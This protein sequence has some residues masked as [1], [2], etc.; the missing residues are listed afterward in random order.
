MS[1]SRVC[2]LSTFVLITAIGTLAQNP[3]P[4]GL[5]VNSSQIPIPLGAVNPLT[6]N[7]HLE[8]PIASIPQRNGHTMS[9][10]LVFDTRWQT[11]DQFQA[12]W[13]GGPGWRLVFGPSQQGVVTSTTTTS[14]CPDGGYPNGSAYTTSNYAI[15]DAQGTVHYASTSLYV[16]HIVCR[17]NS[18]NP[19]PNTGSPSG[20]SAGDIDG[21]GYFFNV[22]NYTN[23]DV[24]DIDDALVASDHN[25]N[26]P[27][28]TNGNYFSSVGPLKDMF[29]RQV[30]SL[31]AQPGNECPSQLAPLH[32]YVRASDGTTNTYT[33][34]C[35]S[36][37]ISEIG[38]TTQSHLLPSSLALPDGTSYTFNYDTGTTGNHFGELVGV[39]LPS[40]GQE[41]FGYSCTNTNS[42][43][44][45]PCDLNS[46][47]VG[48][49]TW[50]LSYTK[51]QQ[52]AITTATVTEPARYDSASHQYL[53]DQ[54]KYNATTDL[55]GKVASIQYYSGSSTLLKTLSYAYNA[56]TPTLIDSVTTTLNDTGQSSRIQYQYY[57]NFRNRP[58][59]IQE[60]D[61][62][63]ST[64]TRTRK[65]AYN[66]YHKPTSDSIY[67]GDGSSGSPVSQT[68]YTYDEYN[69]SY[70]Q[71]GVPM[72]ASVTG[73]TNHDDTNYGVNYTTRG[74]V[75]SISRWV[76]GSTWVTSHKCYDTLG[77]VTQDVDEAG[78]Y[79]GY[80][81]SETWADTSCIPTGTTT[82][83]YPTTITDPVGNRSKTTYF[84]C[85]GLG[86]ARANE[87]D[88]GA[89][90]SGTTYTYD[91]FGR[92]LSVNYPDGG[93]TNYGYTDAPTPQSSTV[94][95]L[96]SNTVGYK[97]TKS[98]VDGYGRVTQ[99]QL[100]SD[101]VIDYKDTT[102]DAF[103]RPASVSNAYRAVSDSTYGLTNYYY[104]ALGRTTSV[105][106]PDGS[107]VNTTYSGN[108]TTVAD[109]IGKKRKSQFDALGRLTSVW[110]D[111]ANLNY[112]TD[113]FYDVLGDLICVQQQGGVGTPSGTGCAYSSTGDGTSPWRIRRFAY[114][115]LSR[116]N[117]A[118]NPEAG[119]I[120]Y[121]YTVDGLLQTKAAPAPN[122]T[123]SAQVTTT[124]SYDSGHR[125]T[126]KSYSDGKTALVK[127][128]YDGQNLTGC[129]SQAPPGDPDSN[130]KGYRTA[131]CD[132]SGATNWKHDTMG[133]IVR[134]RRTI[135][136]VLGK[137]ETNAYN[138]DGSP[139]SITP[140]GGYGISYTYNG[141]GRPLTATNYTGGTN[142]LVSGAT[143]APP[144]QLTAMTMGLTSTFTGI[145][146][147][148]AYNNRLQPI[149]LSASV[150]GQNTVFS[151]CFDFHL[152]V[153]V[154]APPCTFSASTL[155]DNGNVYQIVN[156]T[157][158][159]HSRD[160]NF[161]YDSLNRIQ[162]A[163]SSG[164]GTFS[165]GETYSPSATGP[166]VPPTIPGIDA[167]GNLTNRS[168]VT[169]K[170]YTEPLNC[171]ANGNNQLTTC[172]DG[173]DAAG[174]MT[175]NGSV[176]Y[177]YGA[178]NRLVAAGGY[179]YIYDGDGQRVEKCTEGTAAGNCAS[180]AIGTLYWRGTSSDTL[181]ETDLTGTMQNNYVFF[182]GQRVARRDSAG[183]VH[184]YFSDYLGSHGVVE[185]ATASA[186]EQDLDYYPYGGVENDYCP[187]VAQNYKFTGKERD[188][189]SGLDNFGAR[190][191]ASSLGR[192]MSPDSLNTLD[193]SHPQKLNRYTYGSNNPISNVD[194]GGQCTAP[195]VAGGQ[196][197]ICVESYIRTRFLPGRTGK[198][199]L[200][201]HRG[202]NPYGGTFRTQTLL[203]VDPSSHTVGFAEK[204][205]AGDSCAILGCA[206]GVNHSELSKISH[207]D[208]GNTYFT[209]TVY[210]ENG[211]EAQGKWEA[212]GGWIEM[213]FSFRVDSSGHVIVT[214]AETKGYPSASIYSYN[215][216]GDATDVWEQT[217]SGHSTDLY[218]P[219]KA[220]TSENPGGKAVREDQERQCKLGNPA[221]CEMLEPHFPQDRF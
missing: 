221:A 41:T 212:P 71:N 33:L 12:N 36:Y 194:V 132:G 23:Q 103:G 32:I 82:H 55:T 165:W 170:T 27:E 66:V 3:V 166:G 63:A 100:T 34:N 176:P 2:L 213:Q 178:E 160:Q 5:P 84:T 35:Q 197:G 119:T 126:Q 75:T 163:Y 102:Y 131:M 81:Y 97:T 203:R 182:N 207:D 219:R 77:N 87:N 83:G 147:N 161:L 122:Q 214:S 67:A 104:D 184:Y 64:P 94:S 167:W 210:G 140:V 200:G 1:W 15:I 154:S 192:F 183:L 195:A 186:C 196:V 89:G 181:A 45:L 20:G 173:Y 113:Y 9:A 201:D 187:I 202:K 26:Y 146:T 30:I 22:S 25:L 180:G 38:Y 139:A 169:G 11:L 76:S 50:N 56:I 120:S 141:A 144:G 185:N 49:G 151:L 79:T 205:A 44:S 98:I 59:Q 46:F 216:A 145:V 53:N 13:L 153:A 158:S 17:D 218:G 95:T 110:E 108:T 24:Y 171:P 52:G 198:F 211:Y 155:G 99:K 193:I 91:L 115:G 16:Y 90:R 43:F 54:T 40:G 10:K 209:L 114:D 172:S 127:F 136:T 152:G 93:Q 157:D 60:F 29:E 125:L 7:V 189:E 37:N 65:L 162:Q 175:S 4:P 72:L 116:L 179:S 135:G 88:I 134:E 137:Y 105:V 74:N 58:S 164:S 42:G 78:H 69:A 62:G 142:K 70:C 148:N 14:S 220:A 217:E 47:S 101:I 191:D 6:E 111:P 204:P 117:S 130:S 215:S 129:P 28:D 206:P 118:S 8:I 199:A 85:T 150:S 109:E 73:A 39:T 138:L 80:D 149:L 18:G 121:S 174:N 51:Q 168:G 19:D 92:P 112:E 143:Y 86:Q 128:A 177:V 159:T 156:N 123:G 61:Y 31:D 107:S 188:S 21:L 106:D 68:T 48:G 208:K 133:R 190:Y 96:I 124:Y 57:D